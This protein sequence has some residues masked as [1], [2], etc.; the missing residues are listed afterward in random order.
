M[1]FEFSTLEPQI[2]H[3]LSAPGTDLTT[4]SAKRVRRQLLELDPT[5]T[6]DFLKDNKEDVDAVIASVFE[7]VSAPN[8]VGGSQNVEEPTSRKRKQEE[9]E[10]EDGG[11]GENED[12]N[13]EEETPPPKKAK[14]AV[15]K[16][17]SD[18]EL[19]RKLSSEIN[20]RSRRT[21]GKSRGN[22]NGTT[23]K[24]ARAKKSAAIIDSDDDDSGD[25]VSRKTKP[26][27]KSTAGGAA[28]G[29]FAKEYALRYNYLPSL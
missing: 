4:I 16:E 7:K 1:S 2:Y 3:I 25:K 19:A 26:K 18:A 22:A 28:K 8:G 13:E 6:V 11:E 9:D 15:K 27:R 17:L 29:G 21:T 14:K 12:D 10:T 24:G 23:K 5:L 20:S